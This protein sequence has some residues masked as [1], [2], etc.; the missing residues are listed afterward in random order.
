MMITTDYLEKKWNS[1][2]YYEG[3]F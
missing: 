2:T 1:V 3:G